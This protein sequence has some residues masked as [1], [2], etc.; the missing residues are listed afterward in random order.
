MASNLKTGRTRSLSK[1]LARVLLSLTAGLTLLPA[2]AHADASCDALFAGLR[3]K[4]RENAQNYVLALWTTNYF[5]PGRDHRFMSKTEIVMRWQNGD[6]FGSQKRNQIAFSKADK[7]KSGADD[8]SVRI[9]ADGKLMFSEQYGP[10]DPKC[11]HD[12]FAIVDSGDS[13][14]AFSFRVGNDVARN[15]DAGDSVIVVPPPQSPAPAS[16][17]QSAHV[18]P[19]ARQW[20][21]AY[22]DTVLGNEEYGLFNLR[23]RELGL[24]DQL[25]GKHK[26]DSLFGEVYDPVS[27]YGTSG[28]YFLFI[29][30]MPDDRSEVRE[31]ETFA[32]YNTKTKRYLY[33]VASG[34]NYLPR[35]K[36]TEPSYEWKILG[37]TGADFALF[38][39]KARSWF[40]IQ[41]DRKHDLTTCSR[42]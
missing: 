11:S 18:P 29:R 13:V 16:P 4:A 26:E 42:S 22:S 27:W 20:N 32:I 21:V 25:G 9:R 6:L 35:W 30:P 28:G 38:N 24:P 5:V 33:C 8:S 7:V 23:R 15:L 37:R 12:K 17:S 10:Y 3:A 2:A 31:D 34:A 39:I 41:E 1:Q 36:S 14:E 40:V 19:Q